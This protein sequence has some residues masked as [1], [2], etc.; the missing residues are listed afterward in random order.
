MNEQR[1]SLEKNTMVHIISI[2]TFGNIYI[3]EGLENLQE[4]FLD[5]LIWRHREK[6]KNLKK[7]DL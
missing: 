3:Y 2:H 4:S 6:R 7:L 5:I 1:C